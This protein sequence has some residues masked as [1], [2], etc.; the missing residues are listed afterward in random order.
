M[1]SKP[2]KDVEMKD[3]SSKKVEEKKAVEEVVIDPFYGKKPSP[4][5]TRTQEANDSLRE[6]RQ[7]KGLQDV[8]HINQIIQKAQEAPQPLRHGSGPLPLHPRLI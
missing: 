7:G 6:G 8:C 5:C 2:K 3:E 4:H 1:E